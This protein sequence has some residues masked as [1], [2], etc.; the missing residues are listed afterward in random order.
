MKLYCPEFEKALRREVREALSANPTLKKEYRRG[1]RPS[2][3]TESFRSRGILLVVRLLRSSLLAVVVLGIFRKTHEVGLVLLAINLWALMMLFFL[4]T[5]GLREVSRTFRFLPIADATIC[6]WRWNETFQRSF[7]LLLD[8]ILGLGTLGLVTHA[9]PWQWAVIG[10]MTLFSW[11]F[12]LA[13][14]V[15]GAARFPGVPSVFG[16]VN[17][18]IF[19]FV[20]ASLSV[21]WLTSS[22]LL[23]FLIQLAPWLNSYMPT[24]WPLSLLQVGLP[25]GAWWQLFFII[26]IGWVF[27]KFKTSL[28]LIEARFAYPEEIIFEEPTRSPCPGQRTKPA[29]TSTVNA[30]PWGK[31]KLRKASFLAT[32]WRGPNGTKAGSRTGC[33]TD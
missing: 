24:G 8:L 22:T 17:W 28:L 27:W 15:L 16:T 25:S 7:F 26:P 32:S 14:G 29:P 1:K 18:G 3:P 20:I 21:N 10:A 23:P 5:I 9:S 19:L 11:V 6:Q 33:G 31:P 2:H 13:L 12:M 30:A 4:V